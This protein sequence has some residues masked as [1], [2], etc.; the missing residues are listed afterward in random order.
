[1]HTAQKNIAKKKQNIE[2]S[3]WQ[4]AGNFAVKNKEWLA[5]TAISLPTAHFAGQ[6]RIANIGCSEKRLK[7]SSTFAVIIAKYLHS[8]LNISEKRVVNVY[9][10]DHSRNPLPPTTRN[11]IFYTDI[12]TGNPLGLTTLGKFFTWIGLL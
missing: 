11:E 5:F 1:M 7:D 6:L 3:L 9:H 12:A 2:Q 4:R 10:V 8:L